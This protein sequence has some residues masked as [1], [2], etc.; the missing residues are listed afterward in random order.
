M[1][2]SKMYLFNSSEKTAATVAPGNI[3]LK[4]SWVIIAAV[5]SLNQ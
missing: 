3:K 5:S 4:M 1:W 2:I